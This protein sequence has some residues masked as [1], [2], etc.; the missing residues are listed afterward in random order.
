MTRGTNDTTEARVLTELWKELLRSDPAEQEDFT[1]AGG[2]SLDAMELQL[3]IAKRLGKRLALDALPDPLLFASLLDAVAVAPTV[4]PVENPHP[5]AHAHAPASA[6]QRSQWL[7]ERA[8]PTSWAYVVP[9]LLDLKNDFKVAHLSRA[10]AELVSMH[11]SLRTIIEPLDGDVDRLVQRVIAPPRRIAI[12]PRAVAAVDAASARALLS[13]GLVPPPSISAPLPFRVIGLTVEGDLRGVLLLMHHGAV[14]EWS[15]RVLLE[16][17][18][19]ILHGGDVEPEAMSVLDLGSTDPTPDDLAW[20][21]RTLCEAPEGVVFPAPSCT[22]HSECVHSELSAADVLALDRACADDG[23]E[24][25]TAIAYAVAQAVAMHAKTR[26]NVVSV[27]VPMSLRSDDR[28]ARTCGMF[29]N[30]LPIPVRVDEPSV[31]ESLQSLRSLLREARRRRHVPYETLRSLYAS[32]RID[33]GTPWLDVMVGV[34]DRP[35][36]Q[37]AFFVPTLIESPEAAAPL[38]VVARRTVEGTIVLT[39]QAQPNRVDEA[40]NS[41]IAASTVDVLRAIG[42]REANDRT[43]SMVVGRASVEPP[44]LWEAVDYH[45]KQTPDAVAIEDGVE[46][47]TYERLVHESEQ[48][49]RVLVA[50][51]VQRD[52]AVALDLGRTA[53]FG[54]AVL[55]VIRAGCAPLP[56]Q[57]GTPPARQRDLCARAGV[58]VTIDKEWIEHARSID[59]APLPAEPTLASASYVLFTSGSTGEPKGVRMHHRPLA[60]LVAFERRR[61]G[62]M[63]RTAMLAP[64]GFDVVFQ[65]LFGTWARGGTLIPVSEEVRR[66]PHAL[67]SVIQE[68]SIERMHISPLMLRLLG[69]ALSNKDT[70]LTSLEEV[71]SAGEVLRIDDSMRSL[72]AAAGG[73]NLVNQY[74]PTETH[75]ATSIDLGREPLAWPDVPTIGGSIDGVNVLILGDDGATVAQ[76]FDGELVVGGRGPAVGYVDGDPDG[77]FIERDGERWYR[78]GDVARIDPTGMIEY[79]GRRDDQVKVASHR[80]EVG[81]VE[82][83]LAQVDGVADAA[84]VAASSNGETVLWACVVPE[85]GVSLQSA[86]VERAIK[87]WLPPHLCPQRIEVR[88]TLPIS[89]NG[90]VNRRRLLES[91][92]ATREELEEG[93]NQTSDV[94]RLVG[95]ALGRPP[96]ERSVALSALGLESLGAIKIQLD[97]ERRFGVAIRIVDLLEGSI[98]DLER[99]ITA[100]EPSVA[101]PD[102]SNDGEQ[103]L[104]EQDLLA[105]TAAATPG[106]FHLAWRIDFD[107]VL[108]PDVLRASLQGLR[109]RH[110]SL[111]TRRTVEGSGHVEDVEDLLPPGVET[112]Q[113]EPDIA[114]LGGLIRHDLDFAKGECLRALTWP[115]RGGTTV[116]LV[117]HHAAIDGRGAEV[118]IRE[119]LGDLDAQRDVD[120]SFAL[121]Q[122][123]HGDAFVERADDVAWWVGHV[124]ALFADELPSTPRRTGADGLTSLERITDGQGLLALARECARAYR[125]QPN[126]VVLAAWAIMV[127]RLVGRDR[128]LIGVPFAIDPSNEASIRLGAS[129]L[130]LSIDVSSHRSV[131]DVIASVG[132][133]LVE[134]IEHRHA[135][136]GSVVRAC[137]G[138]N[139]LARTPIDA[140]F[141]IDVGTRRLGGATVSWEPA[142]V[143]PFQAALVVEEGFAPGLVVQAENGLLNGETI[144]ACSERFTAVLRAFVASDQISGTVG[145]LPFESPCQ[146][147][148]R[149]SFECGGKSSLGEESLATRFEEVVARAPD[150]VAIRCAEG[151][152]SYGDLEAWSRS[153]ASALLAQGLRPGDRVAL[154]GVRSSTALATILGIVRAGGVYVPIDLTI[155]TNRRAA[156]LKDAEVR[157]A[158][159]FDTPLEVERSLA[160]VPFENDA[161]PRALPKGT[162]SDGLYVMFTSGTSGEP[163]GAL[164]SHKAVAR[165]CDEQFFLSLSSDDCMLHAAPLG[166]DAST[167]ELWAPLLAG[168]SIAVWDGASAD[169]LGLAECVAR[170]KC[171]VAW[172]TS[173][174]FQAAVD[175]V[176]SIFDRLEVLLTGGDVVSA[177]HVETVLKRNP[178]LIV[179]N[180]Y[181]PTENTVFTS[182]DVITASGRPQGDHLSI[183]RPIRGTTVRILGRNGECLPLG[184]AGELVAGGSGLASMLK[185]DEASRFVHAEGATWYRTGDVARWSPD[186]RLEFLGRLDGQVKIS[187]H[188]VEP[189]AVEHAL[190]GCDGV[191]DACVS[192]IG[193]GARR[194]LVA[195]V[196]GVGENVTPERLRLRVRGVLS[197]AEVPSAIVVVPRLPVTGNGKVDRAA[198]ATL[199]KAVPTIDG[200]AAASGELIDVISD[201]VR[202]TLGP[203]TLL[204]STLLSEA[205]IDSLDLVRLTFALG[206]RLAR[207]V[208]L[209]DVLRGGSIEGIAACVQSELTREGERIVVLRNAASDASANVY[210]V[211]GVGG[212][213]FSFGGLLESIDSS[214]GVFGLPYPGLV[215][216][217]TPL[218]R[219][220]ALA[221]RFAE[222]IIS[223]RPATVILGYSLGGLVAFE[224]ARR[225]LER[226]G[227][228]PDVVV[229]DTAPAAL[230]KWTLGGSRAIRRSL[231][232]RLEAVLPPGVVALVRGR[233]KETTLDSLRRVVAAGFKAVRQ[234]KPTPAALNVTLVRTNQTMFGVAE[235]IEDLGWSSLAAQTT[236][237]RIDGEHLEVFRGNTAMDVGLV[238]SERCARAGRLHPNRRAFRASREKRS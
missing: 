226:T 161:P 193:E 165:L 149:K 211:P 214:I 36:P 46:T 87:A 140:V 182:C 207:P 50:E 45:A 121:P 82:H 2:S 219:V 42:G 232:L 24:P 199:F 88:T 145:S 60:N 136:I 122:D 94:A 212:T 148:R 12:E 138:Q 92:E 5:H 95:K 171:T 111:R 235:Q 238:V 78:T 74:G 181:G 217:E 129:M 19:G 57:P 177:S 93:E 25:A 139:V 11:P 180:G 176:P 194:N 229:I 228:A 222:E 155:P 66:D 106:A 44:T 163:K 146:A 162:C 141:T 168:G 85:R 34:V 53:L 224:T 134:G 210:C 192:V 29:L 237:R 89:A 133:G 55:G 17:L 201:V 231:K 98:E 185:N 147:R 202:T 67:A 8:N 104:L 128:V 197:P 234:Y 236:V 167:L 84:V 65:E 218:E 158:I 79:R 152:Y 101:T 40:T 33:R 39:T 160:T 126:T 43:L 206:D 164:V 15:L 30:T 153:V 115:S 119:L 13:D 70:R 109:V 48:I 18:A 170:S 123:E 175:G 144:E 233:G 112:L 173:A 27:G 215:S 187:G 223:F 100:V 7:F 58:K 64:L 127:G 220:E 195:A 77:R 62:A 110:P 142:G 97:L 191:S 203:Q 81:E 69:Q 213:V 59:G 137:S 102:P 68:H 71:I 72:A 169:L 80:V 63:L 83:V 20:W 6:A 150:A 61:N 96:R 9:V 204:T 125:V 166:F 184:C 216:R 52:A 174:L 16:D 178:A 51:G 156:M 47:W 49:A 131:A 37:S 118:L 1:R 56:F 86:R 75:V 132:T 38:L 22:G 230:P 90:K 105:E 198:V 91:L 54:I 120:S 23:V 130:P 196:A 225:V 135:S 41:A 154:P 157:C 172:L 10:V 189:S 200:G 35:L 21:E 183:G 116:I 208:Q 107:E 76:G 188:R 113:A 4:T 117:L 179:V 227:V 103:N 159:G 14:D 31:R 108:D 32:R 124:E 209:G 205:G 114:S 221:E 143:S 73:F 26:P 99:A 190:R 151:T 28:L 186:G 3:S